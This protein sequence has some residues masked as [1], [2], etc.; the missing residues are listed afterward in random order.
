[1][2]INQLQTRLQ[3]EGLVAAIYTVT[4]IKPQARYY[5]DGH[6]EIFF[7][8][9]DVKK[10]R[11]YVDKLL[12]TKPKKTAATDVRVHA[13]PIL[14]PP[15]AKRALPYIIGLIALGYILGKIK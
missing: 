7:A 3:A 5:T 12:S 15:V 13:L 4:G 14:V 6:A 9:Q 2:P 11:D 10:L 8:D 1:M